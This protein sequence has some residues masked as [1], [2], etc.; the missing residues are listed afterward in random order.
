MTLQRRLTITLIVLLSIASVNLCYAQDVD[1]PIDEIVI[2]SGI[3]DVAWNNSWIVAVASDEGVQLYTEYFLALAAVRI[4]EIIYSVTWNPNSEQIAFSYDDIIEIWNWDSST[5][6]LTL[7][8]TLSTGTFQFNLKWSPGG[9]YLASIGVGFADNGLLPYGR[10]NVWDT[11]TWQLT[12]S[13]QYYSYDSYF[14]PRKNNQLN[15]NTDPQHPMLVSLGSEVGFGADGAYKTTKMLLFTL[16]PAT[17]ERIQEFE[18]SPLSMSVVWQSGGQFVAVGLDTNVVIYDLHT[19]SYY[20][21][22]VSGSNNIAISWSPDGAKLVA[23][24]SLYDFEHNILLGQFR[25]EAL[26]VTSLW[27]EDGNAIL[28]AQYRGTISM[29][30]PT[31]PRG[32]GNTITP[33]GWELTS[34]AIPAIP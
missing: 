9:Q 23:G 33:G 18:I 24:N 15:W 29:E 21:D 14:F 7:D 30:D 32:Y 34:T 19:E 16:D 31:L 26:P 5:N 17:L 25:A 8:R 27:R 2:D 13:P 4:E 10:V 1:N 12:S 28:I 11:T 22:Y 3:Y 6:T 20:I